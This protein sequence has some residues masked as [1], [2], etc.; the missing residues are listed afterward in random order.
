MMMLRQVL[1]ILCCQG[2]II[3]LHVSLSLTLRATRK[4]VISD[5]NLNLVNHIFR[6][7]R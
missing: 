3:D 1:C 4:V 5:D 6:Y 2:Y 7:C